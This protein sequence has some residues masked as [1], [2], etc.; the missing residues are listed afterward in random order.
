MPG[1]ALAAHSRINRPVAALITS[2]FAACAGGTIAGCA[3]DID[4]SSLESPSTELR[5][6]YADPYPKGSPMRGIDAVIATLTSERL[7]VLRRDGRPEPAL[8]ERWQESADRLRWRFT[9]RSGLT[10]QDGSPLTAADV[11]KGLQRIIA[12]SSGPA[13]LPP[14]LRDVIGIDVDAPYELVIR[15]SRP[16]SLLVE[17]L[18]FYPITG[19]RDGNQSAGPFRLVSKS[20]AGAVLEAF[21]G[22][23]RGRPLLDR[24]RIHEFEGAR[25]A[26]SE[27]MRDRVDFLYDVSPEALDFIQQASTTHV[28][29]FLKPYV[30]ALVF[31][32]RHPVLRRRDVRL[33]L[34]AAVNRTELI[35]LALR[36]HGRPTADH[37]W[38]RHWAYD[39]S[40]PL[41]RFDP[42][43]AGA[44]L[45][46]AGL[47]EP[48]PGRA[49]GRFRFSC[50]VPIDNPRIERVAL[51][52]QRQ[53]IEVGVNLELKPVTFAEWQRRMVS[54]DY[55]AFLN[56][57][58]AGHGFDWVH[59]FWRSTP[60]S[61]WF[62][63]GYVAADGP[64]DRLR[65]AGGDG[66][67]KS[68]VRDLQRV[69]RDDPPA[70]FLYWSETARAVSRR[71]L[72]PHEPGRD[73]VSTVTRW[74]AASRAASGSS[75]F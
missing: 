10:W 40:L 49:R 39:A 50:L 12:G 7:L 27:M 48:G 33:A 14:G 9:L 21:G 31:N 36:G 1:K 72:V 53:L 64:L 17:D 20:A 26:W 57:L 55:D 18:A 3:P 73:I 51:M 13:G 11:R 46:A 63:S 24:I 42:A 19:G 68:A 23:H 29:T 69:M 56:D 43:R 35:K 52:A 62:V 61:R 47:P 44:L 60:D 4:R 74:R 6:G 16:N 30:T 45:D 32:L 15:L 65:E 67:V 22:Y 59:W 66:E 58:L 25:L 2:L 8:A 41:P 71:F 75:E 70:I 34:N 37:V 38:P 54:G 5:I 28:A